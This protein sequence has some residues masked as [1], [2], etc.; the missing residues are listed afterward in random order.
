[1]FLKLVCFEIYC[2]SSSVHGF[3]S[4]A[5]CSCKWRCG[6]CRQSHIVEIGNL[7]MCTKGRQKAELSRVV[8]QLVRPEIQLLDNSD[9]FNWSEKEGM[10]DPILEIRNMSELIKFLLYFTRKPAISRGMRSEPSSNCA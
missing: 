2:I 8:L 5:R 9:H 1:M 4:R 6:R 10:N 3:L 7:N